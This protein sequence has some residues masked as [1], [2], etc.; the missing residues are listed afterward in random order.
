M[1][2]TP[3]A[4]GHIRRSQ[5]GTDFIVLTRN[6]KLMTE[7]AAREIPLH[8]ALH[9]FGFVEWV[10]ERRKGSVAPCCLLVEQFIAQRAVEG[11]DE[12]VL[13][14]LARNRRNSAS[15]PRR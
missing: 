9:S 5:A 13:L 4:P 7:N 10:E 15:P 1:G 12:P 14:R 8:P 3:I 6:M 11:L 2:E